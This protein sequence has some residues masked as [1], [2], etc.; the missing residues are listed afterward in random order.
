MKAFSPKPN[1]RDLGRNE[2]HLN[3]FRDLNAL[4]C[5]SF[6]YSNY[7]LNVLNRFRDLLV[8]IRIRYTGEHNFC[9]SN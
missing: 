1:P 7:N 9:W 3:R 8:K 5:S 6:V 2:V 4:D